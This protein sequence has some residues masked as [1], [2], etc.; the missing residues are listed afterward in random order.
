MIPSPSLKTIATVILVA[1]TATACDGAILE[2]GRTP[3]PAAA[4]ADRVFVLESA[5][6]QALPS[7]HTLS[8][9]R[10]L[11]VLAD[12]I[13]LYDE[14]LWRRDSRFF[15][16]DADGGVDSREVV[17]HG[18]THVDGETLLFRFE[19]I[20]F[21]QSARASGDCVPGDAGRISGP[22]LTIAE[23]HFLFGFG[24]VFRALEE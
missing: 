14:G 17:L 18:T 1:A 11:F 13:R 16:A 22:T 7:T 15:V 5:D 3:P 24:L 20:D 9:E 4:E 10:A 21:A 6:G 19:C 12:T 2:T 23:S 8:G